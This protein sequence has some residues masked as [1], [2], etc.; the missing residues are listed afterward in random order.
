MII[1]WQKK[2]NWYKLSINVIIIKKLS[3]LL[4]LPIMG[5]NATT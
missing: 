2:Y 5:N 3:S 4:W 1:K